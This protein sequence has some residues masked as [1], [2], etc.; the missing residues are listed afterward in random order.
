L[1]S[2]AGFSHPEEYRSRCAAFHR[3]PRELW[4]RSAL[5][6]RFSGNTERTMTVLVLFTHVWRGGKAGGAETH[7][8]DLMRELALRGHSV[9]F[10][11]S[12]DGLELMKVPDGVVAEY[13]LRFQSINPFDKVRAY[14]QLEE[15]VRR[16]RVGIVH[17]HHR[18]G[19]Y[20]AEYLFRRTGVPY[21][22][23]VHDIWHRAP[24]K[25]LHGRIFRRL[26]AVSGFIKKRL[27]E[28]FGIAPES[29]RVI[30]NGVNPARIERARSTE[31]D[32]FR[33][34]F[35]IGDEVVFSLVARITRS[36]GH[37]DV[38]EAL[39]LLP[40]DLPYKCVM[41]GEGRDKA[42]LQELAARHGLSDRVVFCGFQDDVPAVMKASDVILLPSHREPFAI[43]ILEGMFSGK[44]MLVSDSGG[45]PEAVANGREGIVFPV[46]DVTALAKG[47]ELL[48][49]DAGLR[50]R[51]GEQAR[52]TAYERFQLK[53]MIDATEAY[54][55]EILRVAGNSSRDA[56][57]SPL[58]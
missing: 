45:T 26:I 49:R 5:G 39:R 6:P 38:I 57:V 58:R 56:R 55:A 46:R 35:D 54:Y 11:A 13:R 29:V 15:I 4:A 3:E 1:V 16:H 19:G 36:K 12:D 50:L 18:T 31:A 47:I 25:R 24:L 33:K 2:G 14:H 17:A 27:E 30:H 34:Q 53:T 9:V 43:T 23:T 51:L 48:A 44:P 32:S 40:P 52:R 7:A 28:N 37:Y 10:V 20:F 21:V 41:V 22:I 8:V 42:K